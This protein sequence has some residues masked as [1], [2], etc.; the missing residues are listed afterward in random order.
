VDGERP[1]CARSWRNIGHGPSES[2]AG[3]RAEITE[4][5]TATRMAR[6]DGRTFTVKGRI[7]VFDLPEPG[8]TFLP[9]PYC[10]I[11]QRLPYQT[12]SVNFE[13]SP[14]FQVRAR[15]PKH[16]P[17]RIYR[18]RLP[19]IHFSPYCFDPLTYQRI[20]TIAEQRGARRRSGR[21]R[22]RRFQ[23]DLSQTS[24]RPQSDLSQTSV[25]PGRSA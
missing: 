12:G 22:R 23:S 5:Q 1:V 14:V 8:D 3:R 25:R 20:E 6:R 19:V 11:S 9:V 4:R 15:C 2:C 10:V 7:A 16:P 13:V 21:S 24:V 18:G 17:T